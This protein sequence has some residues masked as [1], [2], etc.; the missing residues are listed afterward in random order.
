MLTH[1]GFPRPS[2]LY[3]KTQSLLKRE[4]GLRSAGDQCVEIN[5]SG[6]CITHWA[7]SGGNLKVLRIEPRIVPSYTLESYPPGS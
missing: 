2:K 7:E 6:T 4:A 3:D 1:K 5:C